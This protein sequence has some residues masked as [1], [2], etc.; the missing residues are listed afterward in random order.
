MSCAG[1]T[2]YD[3]DWYKKAYQEKENKYGKDFTNNSNHSEDKPKNEKG[4]SYKQEFYCQNVNKSSNTVTMSFGDDPNDS[5]KVIGLGVCPRC[6][7]MF[8]VRTPKRALYEYNYTCPLCKQKI[9]VRSD[10]PRSKAAKVARGLFYGIGIVCIIIIA[11]VLIS[12]YISTVSPEYKSWFT[13]FIE[14]VASFFIK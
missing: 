11:F 4:V 5:G 9:Y 12:S 3:R 7:N 2:I 14:S 13:R 1:Y 6:Y 8:R 10:K